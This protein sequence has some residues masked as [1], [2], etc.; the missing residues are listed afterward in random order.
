MYGPRLSH[1][2]DSPARGEGV[3]VYV[4]SVNHTSLVAREL[5][6]MIL[7]HEQCYYVGVGSFHIML[8]CFL[9]HMM[10]VS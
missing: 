9:P 5:Q 4:Y 8:L 10:R 6:K 7:R 1:E 3:C 2:N